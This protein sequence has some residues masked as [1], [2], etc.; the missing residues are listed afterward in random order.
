MVLLWVS[1]L[2]VMA[3]PVVNEGAGRARV[4]PEQPGYPLRQIGN[5]VRA[6]AAAAWQRDAAAELLG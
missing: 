5:P 6:D 1:G 3:C 4:S 2:A